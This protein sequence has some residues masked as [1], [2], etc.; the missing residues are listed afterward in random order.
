MELNGK[1]IAFLGDSITEGYGPEK[2]ENVYWRR[3][4]ACTGA[5]VLGYGVGGTRIARQKVA[6][7]ND[8]WTEET[9]AQRA[10]TMPDDLDAIVIFGGTNDFGTG[11]APLGNM[12]SRD[13]YSFYGACHQLLEYLLTRYTGKPIVVMTPLH[14]L[15]ES[16]DT[17]N[18]LGLRR[19]G[20]LQVYVDALREVAAY[21]GIPVVD[22]FREC[23]I[24]PKV[25]AVRRMF[26]PDGLH[27]NDAGHEL[28][29]RLLLNKL[30]AL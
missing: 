19:F 4:G 5:E 21:Y 27:P 24:Q 14:R 1:K 22:L 23:P 26:M 9:F 20:K 30:R 16:D 7:P 17:Y 12:D 10:E 11:D 18:E 3:I 29:A 15:S 25:E 6:I 2:P 13:V 8:P 28:I